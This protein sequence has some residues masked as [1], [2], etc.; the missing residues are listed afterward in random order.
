MIH[1]GDCI[2][3]HNYTIHHSYYVGAA[4]RVTITDV[5]LLK[6]IMVKEFDNFRDR[7]MLGPPNLTPKALGLSPGLV[8]ATGETW[9]TGRHALT[10][11][12]SGMKMKLMVPLLKKS[13]DILLEKI[14]EFAESGESAEMFRV[15]GAFTMETLIATA[16]GRYVNVLRGEA[17]QITQGGQRH[18]PCKRRGVTQCSRHADSNSVQLPVAR[19]TVTA[20]SS[21]LRCGSLCQNDAQYGHG[22]HTG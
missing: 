13:S 9:K 5:E 20:H 7:G 15:Y 22:A 19:A 3:V 8:V 21:E 18:F 4:A 10:P 6:E 16:F 1:V 2:I 14:G 11:S 17:D 12:F